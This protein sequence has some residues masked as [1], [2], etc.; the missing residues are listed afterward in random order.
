MLVEKSHCGEQELPHRW[1]SG[2]W[3]ELLRHLLKQSCDLINVTILHQSSQRC[4]CVVL[5]GS[6]TSWRLT[7]VLHPLQ[8]TQDGC[9]NDGR[10]W[11]VPV[12]LI[13]RGQTGEDQS[14]EAGHGAK[15]GAED[16]PSSRGATTARQKTHYWNNKIKM[17]VSVTDG[18]GENQCDIKHHLWLMNIQ[19][20]PGGEVSLHPPVAQLYNSLHLLQQLLILPS[21]LLLLSHEEEEEGFLQRE[22]GWQILHRQLRLGQNAGKTGG[23]ERF[24]WQL[25]CF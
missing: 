19:V 6:P 5:S 21:I 22:E 23:S 13:P 25:R 12:D 15:V 20:D 11:G 8:P 3:C 10:V 4:Y 1:W 16:R 9:S 18:L 7:S 14:G 2:G 17:C 24:T